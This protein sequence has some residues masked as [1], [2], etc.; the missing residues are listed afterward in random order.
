VIAAEQKPP[1]DLNRALMEQFRRAA[2]YYL[3]DMPDSLGT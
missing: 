3:K 2:K 1:G